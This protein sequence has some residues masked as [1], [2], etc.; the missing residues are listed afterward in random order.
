MQWQRAECCG[1]TQRKFHCGSPHHVKE[2]L[3]RA[4][5]L[6]SGAAKDRLKDA[7]MSA[8]S[9]ASEGTLR[10]RVHPSSA[11]HGPHAALFSIA[12]APPPLPCSTCHRQLRSAV[13]HCKSPYDSAMRKSEVVLSSAVLSNCHPPFTRT[14]EW[15]LSSPRTSLHNTS[16]I[17]IH[18]ERALT[19]PAYNSVQCFRQVEHTDGVKSLLLAR[20]HGPRKK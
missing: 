7:K 17:P 2:T 13:R 3:H 20:N 11:Q 10:K 1:S 19:R 16:L 9:P 6:S 15:S 4:A 14:P 5:R 12:H 18:S 8:K